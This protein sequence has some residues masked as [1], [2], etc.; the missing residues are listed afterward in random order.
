MGRE[1]IHAQMTNS[2]LNDMVVRDMLAPFLD[3]DDDGNGD[4]DDAEG[5]LQARIAKLKLDQAI[6]EGSKNTRYLH[7]RDSVP[8]MTGCLRFAVTRK[9]ESR[10]A[11]SLGVTS[12]RLRSA[13]SSALSGFQ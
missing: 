8:E 12:S 13:K 10:L 6:L 9:V 2:Y 3:D 11:K 1:N 5:D 7:S 4:D